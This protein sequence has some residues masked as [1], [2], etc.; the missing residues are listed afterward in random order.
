LYN[1]CSR[2]NRSLLD[3][4]PAN[5]IASV[6]YFDLAAGWETPWRGRVTLGIRNAFDRSPPPTLAGGNYTFIP[7]YDVPGRFYYVSYRQR[8]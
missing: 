4:Y 6:T 1:L 8:F 7:D 2:P 5:H 3:G